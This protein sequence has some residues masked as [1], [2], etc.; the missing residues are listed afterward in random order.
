[1]DVSKLTVGDAYKL[2]I[3]AIVP[4]PIAWVSTISLE[5]RLNLAP[6]S[7]FN[8]VCSNPPSLLFCPVNHADGREKDTLRNIREVKQFAV[9]IVSEEL[10]TQMNQTSA[11]YP[12]EV[13][14][15][16]VVGLN[17]ARCVKLD[18]PRVQEAPV[19]FECEL[20]EIVKVGPGGAGSGHVVIGKI[21]Y[22]HFAPGVYE[23]GRVQLD[24]VNPIARLA[25]MSYC[26][27]REVF[28]LPRPKLPPP[29]AN[30]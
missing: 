7:F 26:P 28:E 5:G 19:T 17:P 30:N 11:D 16:N 24:K 22:A 20:L 13:N 21:V 9:N 29:S 3:G 27:V 23:S 18:V 6:F 2:L 12:P 10:A 1:M 8:G 25:G 4:R 15:F 14:E